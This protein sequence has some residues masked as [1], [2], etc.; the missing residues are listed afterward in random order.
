MG[1]WRGKVLY[2]FV[3]FSQAKDDVSHQ[4]FRHEL[5]HVYQLR[6]IGWLWFYLK[7]L[8]L[9]VRYGY[10]KHPFELEADERQNDPLTEQELAMKCS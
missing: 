1:K 10:R 9:A 6:R 4:L 5:E 2:P 3:L 8:A 7:Y